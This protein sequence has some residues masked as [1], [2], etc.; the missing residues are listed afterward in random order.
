MCSCLKEYKSKIIFFFIRI[1][2]QNIALQYYFNETFL[3]K[4]SANKAI[5]ENINVEIVSTSSIF[6]SQYLN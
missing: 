3:K 2:V 6:V 4:L 1:F 5:Y